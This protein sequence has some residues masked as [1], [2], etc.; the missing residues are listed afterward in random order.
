M[1]VSRAT[2]HWPGLDPFR[3]QFRLVVEGTQREDVLSVK[4]ESG[5]SDRIVAQRSGAAKATLEIPDHPA[6]G[7][8]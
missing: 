5:A 4:A 8:R 1:A 7:F 6:H 2:E 3:W